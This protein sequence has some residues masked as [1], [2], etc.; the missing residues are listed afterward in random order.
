MIS[1][2]PFPAPPTFLPCGTS[3]EA[4]RD[5]HAGV[6]VGHR[7]GLGLVLL[8]CG[9]GASCAFGWGGLCVALFTRERILLC[10]LPGLCCG[11]VHASLPQEAL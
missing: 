7:G 3:L 8:L 10:L 6:G 9:C 5:H 11:D 1:L 4:E 2:S